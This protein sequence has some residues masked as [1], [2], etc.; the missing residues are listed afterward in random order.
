MRH[1]L[2]YLF[3]L[4]FVALHASAQ[5]ERRVAKRDFNDYFKY[6]NYDEAL[7]PDYTL[8]DAL[9]CMDGTRVTDAATWAARRRPELVQL[10]TTYMYGRHPEPDSTFTC[11]LTGRDRTILGGR[12]LRRDIML[13][14]TGIGPEVCLTL[15][16]PNDR[17]RT[18]RPTIVGL[19]F[20]DSDSIFIRHHDGS[21]PKGAEAWSVDTLLSRGYALATFRYTDAELDKARD[22]YRSSLLHRY[23]YR[24]GQTSPMPDE[25]GAVSCWAWTASRAAD[26]LTRLAA[27]VTDMQR[28]AILGHS[29][30][31]KTALWA[32]VCDTRFQTVISVNSGCCGAALSRRCVGETVECVNEWSHQWFCD[33]FVQFSHREEY[34]PFD[35]HELLALI[36]PRS[37]FVISGTEDTWADPKGE[38]LAC[39]AARPVYQLY[40][41]PDNLVYL[42]REGPHAVLPSDWS[43]VLSNMRQ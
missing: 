6:A 34:M 4:A 21:L 19:S 15:V 17:R 1:R 8:P 25:W 32:G 11:T 20:V 38:G 24:P 2:L 5:F 30:L 14:L 35:Q 3:V 10:F 26:A 12:A 33:N 23:F 18:P 37:L 31:G 13:R 7:V 27:D 36:A 29:R 43:F 16:W 39:D 42:L 40:G 28:L 41:C 22:R 9:L